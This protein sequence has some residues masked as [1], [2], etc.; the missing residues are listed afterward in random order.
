MPSALH[1]ELAIGCCFSAATD[2]A[3]KYGVKV[4]FAPSRSNTALFALRCAT[5]RD[6]SISKTVVTCG[7]V[8]LERSMCSAI[9]RRIDES[10]TTSPGM[11]AAAGTGVGIG[12][13]AGFEI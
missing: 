6:M 8:C 4:R 1:D 10:E 12:A 11:G 3:T 9:E 13:G 7:L 5:M 2:T